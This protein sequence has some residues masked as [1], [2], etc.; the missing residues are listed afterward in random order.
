MSIAA[1]LG[2][3]L[4]KTVT[5]ADSVA[6]S[7]VRGTKCGVQEFTAAFQAELAAK[8]AQSQVAKPEVVQST[9]VDFTVC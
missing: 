5:H 4:A 9:P 8:K 2:T 1:K 6:K 3:L 7:A